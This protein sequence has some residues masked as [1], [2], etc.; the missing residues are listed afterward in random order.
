MTRIYQFITLVF[1]TVVALMVFFAF[2]GCSDAKQAQKGYNKFIKHG[3]KIKPEYIY[4]E[5]ID[6]VIVNGKTEYITVIDSVKVDCPDQPK[7]RYEARNERKSKEDSLKYALKTLKE[8]NAFTIDSLNKVIRL[9]RIQKKVHKI[10]SKQVIKQTK[11]LNQK[12]FKWY[13]WILISIGGIILLFIGFLIGKYL[14][15]LI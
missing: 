1:T 9:A 12:T 6:S 5:R 3:G 10:D 8:K 11:V 14:S 13:H 7:T 2:T 4:T 15:K